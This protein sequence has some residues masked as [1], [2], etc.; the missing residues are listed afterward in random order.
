MLDEDEF[1]EMKHRMKNFAAASF[2][3][4]VFVKSN[5]ESLCV[6]V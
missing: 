6:C 4:V 3:S 1:A 2:N 5:P